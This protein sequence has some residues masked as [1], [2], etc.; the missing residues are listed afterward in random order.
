MDG[1][2]TIACDKRWRSCSERPQ[3]KSF[4]K[5]SIYKILHG[6]PDDPQNSPPHIFVYR[7]RTTH[8]LPPRL[9][10]EGSTAQKAVAGQ[11][12]YMPA[13]K[14]MAGVNTGTVDAVMLDTFKVPAGHS[15]WTVVEVSGREMQDQFEVH[16]H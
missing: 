4:Y 2:L 14:A 3:L 6:K 16:K 8:H 9:A 12:Y 5:V 15:V 7:P 10:L 11:C 1:S 13:G